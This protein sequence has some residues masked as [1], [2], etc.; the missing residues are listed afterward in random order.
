MTLVRISEGSLLQL[1]CADMSDSGEVIFEILSEDVVELDLLGS[2]GT[3]EMTIAIE[4]RLQ[5]WEASQRSRGVEV[6]VEILE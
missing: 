3:E 1:L 5:A 6:S 2:Y 4:Q